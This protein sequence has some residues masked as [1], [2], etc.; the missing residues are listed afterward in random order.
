MKRGCGWGCECGCEKH[1]KQSCTCVKVSVSAHFVA[2]KLS[3]GDVEAYWHSFRLFCKQ[4]ES[5][6]HR[7][8]E[9]EGVLGKARTKSTQV[10]SESRLPFVG[11]VK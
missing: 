11:A 8:G 10:A 7:E 3:A 4:A 5:V 1:V 9:R 2:N 6:H